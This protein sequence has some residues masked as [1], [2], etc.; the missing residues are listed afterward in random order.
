MKA[1][2]LLVLAMARSVLRAFAASVLA[3]AAFASAVALIPAGRK[4]AWK[5]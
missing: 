4:G 1:L 5:S 2:V 3:T